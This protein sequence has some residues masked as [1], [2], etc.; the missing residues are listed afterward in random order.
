MYKNY[1]AFT[2]VELI[3]VIT[4][5]AILSAIWFWVYQSYLSGGR[6]ANRVVQLNDIHDWLDRYSINSRLPFPEE[7]IDITAN[8]NTFAYQW[9]AGESVIKTIWYDGWWV[10]LEYGTYLTYMLSTNQKDF[11]LMSYIGESWLLSHNIVWETHANIDYQSLYPK[12][13]WDS[14]W[15]MV[16]LETQEPLHLIELVKNIWTYDVVTW[17]QNIKAYYSDRVYIDSINSSLMQLLPNHNCERIQQLWKSQ[18]NGIY[19]ISPQGNVKLR[20]YCN[21]E[22]NGW[23]W[24]LI[25]RSSENASWENFWWLESHW[26]PENMSELYSMWT[27]VQNIQFDQILMSSFTDAWNIDASWIL[28]WVDSSVVWSALSSTERFPWNCTTITETS[29]GEIPTC[30]TYWWEIDVTNGYTFKNTTNSWF[31]GLTN[32]WYSHS[33]NFLN[34]LRNMQWM[35]F[36]R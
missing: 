17:G 23:G 5:M 33:P 14:L 18:W 16:E 26:N 27:N 35:I 10:D 34:S 30:F 7:M 3:V 20:V 12:V 6:D 19:T 22:I 13:I 21:M 32:N 29:A 8:G 31:H 24:T 28:E 2:F 4:I 9:I 11:Q 15:I 36:I 1:R 25:A